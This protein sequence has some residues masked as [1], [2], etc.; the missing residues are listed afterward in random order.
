MFFNQKRNTEK[1]EPLYKN[2]SSFLSL[3]NLI[4]I[5]I[6]DHDLFEKRISKLRLLFVFVCVII[7]GVFSILFFKK[8]FHQKF[9]NQYEFKCYLMYI[10]CCLYI[11]LISL[12]AAMKSNHLLDVLD[13]LRI[14]SY[15]EEINMKCNKYLNIIGR[16]HSTYLIASLVISLTTFILEYEVKINKL[17]Y[18]KV[19]L[20]ITLHIL[21]EFLLL[22]SY[23]V[24]NFLNIHQFCNNKIKMEI[25]L[26]MENKLEKTFIIFNERSH[27]K[28]ILLQN[29][30]KYMYLQ[31]L[32]WL[33]GMNF[34][35]YISVSFPV[36][37]ALCTFGFAIMININF[38]F[39]LLFE[40]L[41]L[42][43]KLD[44]VMLF[45]FGSLI[46]VIAVFVI[47][48]FDQMRNKVK[49]K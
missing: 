24:L 17:Y 32:L 19:I 37:C 49:I 27:E 25:R 7:G 23:V 8:L 10:Y 34:I 29:I 15:D 4:C 16:K 30:E 20:V 47:I 1:Q 43:E 26:Y 33:Y 21:T 35:R 46:V 3:I 6:L 13:Y 22:C 28:K 40:K 12:T 44:G 39:F 38:D 11:I 9:Q 41:T 45:S 14:I 2:F 48:L 31:R 18:G 42:D 36:G 5:Y